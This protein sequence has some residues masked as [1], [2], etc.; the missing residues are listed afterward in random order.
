MNRRVTIID[1]EVIQNYAPWFALDLGDEIYT[2]ETLEQLEPK[3]KESLITFGPTDG[4]LL[5]GSGAFKFLREYYHFG[6]RSENFDDCTKLWRLSIEGGAYVRCVTEEPSTFEIQEFMSPEFTKKADYGWFKQKVLHTLEEASRFLDW[7]EAQS[8]DTIWALDYEASGMPLDLYFELSGLSLCTIRLGAFISLTDIRRELGGPG[9]PK[10]INLLKRIGKFLQ[11]RMSKIWTYNMQYEFQVSYRMLGVDLYDLCDSGVFNILDGYHLNKKYSLKWTAQRILGVET[12][13]TEFDKISDLVDSMLFTEVGKLKAD[14]KKVLKVTQSDFKNTPEWKEICSRYPKY[15]QEFERLI[16]EYWGNP[17]MCIPSD[18]LGYYCNLDAF[19]TLMLYEA[20][21]N[22]YTQKAIDTF[23][24]NLRLAAR[25]HSCGIPKWEEYRKEY[26]V[27]CEEQMVWGITYCASARCMIKM[28]KHQKKMANIQNYSPICQK[29]LRDNKFFNGDPLLITKDIL[30]SHIDELD[31]YPTGLNEGALVMEYGEDFA[32]K[33][34]EIVRN[35]MV[36]TKMKT[37]IDSGIVRKKK[38]LGIISD[39][40]RALLGLDKLRLGPRH[41]ELEKYLYY[42]RS[43]KELVKV[44]KQIPSIKEVPERIYAF[45]KLMGRLEYSD[46]VSDNLFKCKSPIENDE[47]CLELAMLYPT[48][49]AWLAALRE[50]VHQLEGEKK[51]YKNLGIETPEDAFKHFQ[52][53][54]TKAWGGQENTGYPK[55]TYELFYQ[56][57]QDIKKKVLND[58][59]KDQWS[60]FSGF[61]SQEMFFPMVDDEYLS[62]ESPFSPTDLDNNLRFMRKQVLNYL[63]YKKYSKILSTYI[64]GMFQKTD[65]LVLEDPETH[66]MIRDA[67]P[68]EIGKPGVLWKMRP[69]FQCME[70]SSKRWSSGYHTIISHSDIKSTISAYPGCLLSYFDISSAEVK[71]AGFASGDEHLIDMFVNGVD[72][73][74]AT[75]KLYLGED[76]Y[77]QLSDVE[78][79]TWRKKF[80]T[81]FLGI[82]YGLGKQN[83]AGQLNCDVSEAEKIIQAVYNAY[84]KLREYVE[85]QQEYPFDE[86]RNSKGWGPGTINT[87]FGDRLYL[88]E[89]DYLKKAKDNRERKNI[90]A[91]IKRLAVNL[92]IQGGTSTAMSSGFNNDIRVAKQE[93]WNLCSF[94][95][96]HDSNTT[97]FPVEKLFEI[98]PFFDKNF[99]DFCYEKTGIKLLF[100]ILIGV[101]YQDA[102]EMTQISD[103]EIILKGNARTL[104]MIVDRLKNSTL[105]VEYSMNPDDLIPNYIEDPMQRFIKE[106]GCSMVMDTSKYKLGIKKLN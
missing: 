83:L 64:V 20:R 85:S 80:K 94:L 77:N 18:I 87:F 88:K 75:C 53:E 97:N 49:S 28:Q 31:T 67:T 50:S 46:Y 81:I 62:Y 93:G 22:M 78:K 44:Y 96:V 104:L 79:K 7:A 48:E 34:L 99:T 100:D 54:Y 39:K 4:I 73:Y 72:V 25:L 10:Y 58:S 29:L 42:E 51:Y 9:N 19:Y 52:G 76:G 26:E 45:G 32:E 59:I 61:E 21:K 74:I 98:R 86:S 5:V 16:L 30:S 65:E 27:Y 43:Y 23:L 66:V 60:D 11:D 13:D 63:L 12:W 70:K 38:I 91:R 1:Q 15:I 103:T 6:V 101:T 102:A 41:E 89:W 37:K 47:I 68:D 105:S 84:P 56:Y 92:P 106:K 14:K 71:S 17:F 69:R 82:L 40:L 55:K 24:D 35:A 8:P 2:L 36:E 90:E 57:Y 95:T 33:F 3:K